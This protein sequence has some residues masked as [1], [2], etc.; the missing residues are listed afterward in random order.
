MLMKEYDRGTANQEQTKESS[1]IREW[2]ADRQQTFDQSGEPTHRLPH[3]ASEWHLAGWLILH[4]ASGGCG[5][6][7]PRGA[8]CVVCF[9]HCKNFRRKT[10]SMW[11]DTCFVRNAPTSEQ[12]FRPLFRRC[13]TENQNTGK[14]FSLPALREW[15]MSLR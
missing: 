15:Y 3:G 14:R 6:E 4:R 13:A 5:S 1:G 10:S 11:S 8:P 2:P 7:H 9:G 12:R